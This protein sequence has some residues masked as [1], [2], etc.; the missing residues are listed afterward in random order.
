MLTIWTTNSGKAL[1][2]VTTF[3]VFSNYMGNYWSEEATFT[4]K[5]TIV[6]ILEVIKVIIE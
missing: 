3:Q 6:A 2:K 1:M 4:R 5:D